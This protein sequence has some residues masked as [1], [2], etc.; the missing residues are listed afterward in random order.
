[1]QIQVCVLPDAYRGQVEAAI[2]DALRSAK[3]ANGKAG[4]FHLDRFTFG[5]P[6]ERSALEAAIQGCAGVRGVLALQYRR[7][8]LTPGYIDM[9][10]R[11]EVGVDEIIRVDNDPNFPEKGS[12]NITLG[13]GK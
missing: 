9:P 3:L 11:V 2:L 4:F 8:G 12:I 10:D 1:M 13:G 6:L 5:T 7:R